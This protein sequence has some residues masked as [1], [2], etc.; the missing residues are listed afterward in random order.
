MPVMHYQTH[1]PDVA[2]TRRL[3]TRA[4]RGTAFTWG[5]TGLMTIQMLPT[6][7][8]VFALLGFSLFQTFVCLLPGMVRSR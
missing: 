3:F 7:L 8:P 2:R 1:M 6:T 5:V 4:V